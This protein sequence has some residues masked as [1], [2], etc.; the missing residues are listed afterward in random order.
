MIGIL[1][2]AAV[3]TTNAQVS[4]SGF[5]G[6]QAGD[7][8][9]RKTDATI[10]VPAG[11][12]GAALKFSGHVG[13]DVMDRWFVVEPGRRYVVKPG[14]CAGIDWK[15]V[16]PPK[17]R[18]FLQ[19]NLVE[20][21]LE[22]FPWKVLDAHGKELDTIERP[23]IGGSFDAPIDPKCPTS[24]SRVRVVDA[25]GA[26]RFD[27]TILAPKE[28]VTRITPHSGGGF[29]VIAFDAAN[30][31]FIEEVN[32]VDPVTLSG[33]TITGQPYEVR[34]EHGGDP[35]RVDCAI[36]EVKNGG[37]VARTLSVSS[38]KLMRDY[39][40][41]ALKPTGVSFAPDASKWSTAGEP[42]KSVEIGPGEKK[43]VRVWFEP[44]SVYLV[45]IN[46]W[47]RF[48][49]DFAAGGKTA[50]ATV[51]LSVMRMDPLRRPPAGGESDDP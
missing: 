13:D 11:E 46:S 23:D 7:G 9:W 39:G 29:E 28:R 1:F 17:R 48:S 42:E 41:E 37:K 43:Y 25:K 16:D 15:D 5:L 32:R 35:A 33:L 22:D 47:F 30:L 14:G 45:S 51:P 8:P 3:A 6:W 26:T 20:M 24:G 49:V 31:Y 38:M 27:L 34:H 19:L 12:D 44:A 2:A 21:P 40:E 50:T 10:E 4:V 18:A 36:F